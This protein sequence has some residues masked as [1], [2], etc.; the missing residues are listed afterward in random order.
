MAKQ[1]TLTGSGSVTNTTEAAHEPADSHIQGC[2]QTLEPTSHR[3]MSLK[4]PLA[5]LFYMVTSLFMTSCNKWLVSTWAFEHNNTILLG[6]MVFSFAVLEAFRR[7]GIIEIQS[8]SAG[9]SKTLVLVT[10][11]YLAN[12]GS[13]LTALRLTSVWRFISPAPFH[14]LQCRCALPLMR[15]PLKGGS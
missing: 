4:G 8:W 12:V 5:A 2:H 3:A 1:T 14:L 15:A 7:M 10:L 13:A 9:A 11:F 6:Q